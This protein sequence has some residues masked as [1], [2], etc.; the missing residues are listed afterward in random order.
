MFSQA[1]V[2]VIFHQNKPVTC[3]ILAADCFFDRSSNNCS[4]SILK[5]EKL[6]I[7]D[8]FSVSIKLANRSRVRL[9]SLPAIMQLAKIC[10]H[11]GSNLI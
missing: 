8:R 7:Q 9:K 3:V 4:L 2:P 6:M 11:I 10:D 5:F 1:P